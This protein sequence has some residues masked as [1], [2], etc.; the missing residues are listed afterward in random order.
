M[1]Y[2]LT[3]TREDDGRYS[4]SVSALDGCRATG[5]TLPEALRNAKQAILAYLDRKH[6]QDEPLAPEVE[7]FLS[8]LEEGGLLFAEYEA[9]VDQ[10]L[11]EEA[12]RRLADPANRERLPWERVKAGGR[13]GFAD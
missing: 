12:E 1:A 13:H 8:D 11:A 2:T 5:S 10:G 9:I 3:V 7:A 6:E 4:V